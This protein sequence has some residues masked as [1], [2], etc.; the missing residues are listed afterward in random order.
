MV[1]LP[2]HQAQIASPGSIGADVSST[3]TLAA[4]NSAALFDAS[5]TQIDAVAWGTGTNQYVESAPY[6]QSPATGQVLQRKFIGGTVVDT[7]NNNN[8]FIL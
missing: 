2:G 5:G 4:N 3:E 1:I 7:D 6:S 8:D